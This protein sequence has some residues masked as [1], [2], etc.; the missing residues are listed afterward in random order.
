MFQKRDC[1]KCFKTDVLKHTQNLYKKQCFFLPN[2]IRL[3]PENVS[4]LAVC[5]RFLNSSH[6]ALNDS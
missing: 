5:Y 3:N 6:D 2:E 1:F 4:K